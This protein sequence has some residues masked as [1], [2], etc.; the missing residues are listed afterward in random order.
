VRVDCWAL[1]ELLDRSA[2]GAASLQQRLSAPEDVAA[3][4]ALC[5]AYQLGCRRGA[6]RLTVAV[7]T[8]VTGAAEERRRAEAAAAA[9]AAKA[10]AAARRTHGCHVTWLPLRAAVDARRDSRVQGTL[11]ARLAYHPRGVV[12][13][14]L[15]VGVSHMTLGETAEVEV[16][17]HG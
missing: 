7:P 4:R 1:A 16:S 5:D 9:A 12:V 11:T 8:H 13:R 3:V 17:D 15:D 6:P 2:A 14:G 10:K